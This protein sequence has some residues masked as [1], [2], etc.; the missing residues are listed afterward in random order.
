MIGISDNECWLL[1]YYRSSEISGSLFFGQL[2]R[3]LRPSHIQH[4]LSKHYADE[5]QHAWYWTKCLRELDAEPVRITGSYQDGYLEAVGL[6]GNLM[7]ILAVTLVF[8]RRVINQY[9]RH[10]ALPVIPTPVRDTIGMIM[11]DEKWH[12]AWVSAALDELRAQYGDDTVTD[13]IRRCREADREVYAKTLA[14]HD[15]RLAFLFE[16][17]NDVHS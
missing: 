17:G 4:D 13:A 5:A 7:E 16:G 9:A 11:D 15:E 12:V 8:E 10:L 3:N 1:S 14:E 2:A 6:P